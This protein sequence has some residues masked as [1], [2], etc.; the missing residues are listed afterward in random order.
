VAESDK[1]SLTGQDWTLE[2][3]R[4]TVADYFEMLEAEMMGE[5]VNKTAHRKTLSPKLHGRSNAS[6]EFKH[7]NISRVLVELGLPYIDG[8]KPAK[9][10]QQLLVPEVERYLE[11]HPQF[12]EQLTTS[13]TVSPISSVEVGRLDVNQ[14]I[15][16]PP[17]IIFTPPVQKTWLSR[18]GKMIDFA[19]RDAKNKMLGQ[20]GEQFVF[21][22][23]KTRLNSIGRDDLS[24][25]V[26]LASQTLGDGLGFD[27]ISFD[28][29]TD[30]EK[31]LEVKA[32]GLGKYFPFYVTDNEV[33]CSE[34]VPD[35]YHLFRVFD[36]S[37]N[38]RLYILSGSLRT[39]CRLEPI[40]YRAS[41]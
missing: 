10:R 1:L 8:Y 16:T 4:L 17:E 22:F 13:K 29:T 41:L 31:L 11:E 20:L 32:T 39:H 30:S 33:R 35:Q 15:E 26:L 14:I 37:K 24:E 5:P 21:D 7:Q 25:K 28:E 34:D 12:L 9:N 3:V 6:I 36:F 27:I 40:L 19:E 18:K 2:E 38:P 23:E